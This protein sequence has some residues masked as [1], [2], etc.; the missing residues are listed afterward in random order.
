MGT[1]FWSVDSK[2]ELRLSLHPGQARAWQSDR[3]FVF[4]LAGTQ[5]G[6]TSFGP[7]WLYREIK[8]RGP[9]DYLAVTATFPLLR[10]KML[11]EF[12][13]LFEH[14]LK[15]G[16]WRDSDK[17]F[18]FHDGKTRVIFGSAT[19]PESLESATAKAAWLDEAGQDQFRLESWE[20][21]QRRLSLYE[22]RV[23]AGTTIYNLGWIKQQV[24]DRW[25]RGEPDYAV[26]QF[27]STMNPAFPIAEYERVRRVLPDWKFRMFYAGEF[28]RPAGLIYEDYIDEYREQGGHLVAPFDLPPEWPRYLGVDF[29]GAN[30]ALLWLAYDPQTR[31]FYAYRESLAGS[32]TTREHAT[33][34][35][36]VARGE[37]FLGS[38]GGAQSEAQWRMEWGAWGVP[39]LAPPVP[40]VEIGIDKVI[41]LLQR[42]R[43][44]V[45]DTL[46]GLRDELGTYRRILD[47]SGQTTEAIE[48]KS[49][50][51]RLDA[52]RYV[53]LGV[54]YRLV[55][56]EYV[57]Y[58][59][60]VNISRF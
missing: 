18:F 35:L 55:K 25:Q 56:D 1:E 37:N 7:H 8:D 53:V 38:W 21:V 60:R 58:E 57:I 45:F 51:H 46:A 49:S 27:A 32:K 26:V 50:F 3:R 6:K 34:A 10:L 47:D 59:D 4:V 40:E 54:T 19:H 2:G 48:N 29:G 36:D 14:T 5:G 39:L 20:A 22:G 23:F 33:E 30:T 42:R 12:L 41:E 16:V 43:L 11:P 13:R 24:Y 15:L 31:V 52:L 17:T 44:F 9:G 28:S